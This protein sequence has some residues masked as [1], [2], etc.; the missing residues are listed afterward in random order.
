M[1]STLI[2]MTKVWHSNLMNLKPIASVHD[3]VIG[4]SSL[5]NYMLCYEWRSEKNHQNF[6]INI[7]DKDHISFYSTNNIWRDKIN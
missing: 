6:S 4:T 5:S 3:Y 1:C 7:P 2:E